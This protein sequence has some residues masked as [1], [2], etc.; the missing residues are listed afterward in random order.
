MTRAFKRQT[1][2]MRQAFP[3]LLFLILLFKSMP[4]RAQ[5]STNDSGSFESLK[6]KLPMPV[7]RFTNLSTY[8]QWVLKYRDRPRLGCGGD[9]KRLTIQSDSIM[10]VKNVAAGKVVSVFHYDGLYALVVNHGKY[11]FMYPNLDT[12]F[13]KK[14]DT[15]KAGQPIGKV[16]T[17]SY[18]GSYELE[19]MMGKIGGDRP[20]SIDPYPWFAHS[21]FF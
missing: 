18:G 17:S 13:V 4:G 6:G 14:D 15:I 1:L 12:V 19:L 21:H 8:E 3:F 20:E 16:V 2:L 5:V 9:G 10:T 7:D 11:V